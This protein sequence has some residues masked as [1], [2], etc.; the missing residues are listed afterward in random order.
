MNS[1]VV[2]FM[3]VIRSVI[4]SIGNHTQHNLDQNEEKDD[5]NHQNDTRDDAANGPLLGRL[6]LPGGLLK[7]TMVIVLHGLGADRKDHI[8]TK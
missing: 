7:V 3:I 1:M 5:A 8:H 2:V 4:R 6:L